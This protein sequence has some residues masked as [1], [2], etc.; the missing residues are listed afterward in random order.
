M[1]DILTINRV[2]PLKIPKVL[3]LKASV[4][5]KGILKKEYK[6]DKDFVETLVID[7]VLNQENE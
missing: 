4:K 2:E 7:E 3:Q 6:E 5:T 1:K